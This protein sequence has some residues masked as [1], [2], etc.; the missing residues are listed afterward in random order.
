MPKKAKQRVNKTNAQ[1]PWLVPPGILVGL[2]QHAQM[3]TE[4][5]VMPQPPYCSVWLFLTRASL[6][7]GVLGLLIKALESSLSL[8]LSCSMPTT[9]S[10][11]PPTRHIRDISDNPPTAT[12]LQMLCMAQAIR[13]ENSRLGARC[14]QVDQHCPLTALLHAP[15]GRA[16][17]QEEYWP[18]LKHFKARQGVG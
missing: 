17:H 13:G 9:L 12:E 15:Q 3:K 14:T 8:P 6:Y 11:L 10:F 16:V 5:Q 7:R 2:R 18:A 4:C 1:R